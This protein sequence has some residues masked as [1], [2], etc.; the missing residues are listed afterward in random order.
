[1]KDC[2]VQ[3]DYCIPP[4]DSEVKTSL[5]WYGKCVSSG[6]WIFTGISLR[7]NN[8]PKLIPGFEM[9]YNR[10]DPRVVAKEYNWSSSNIISKAVN[11]I[12]ISDLEFI[13][14]GMAFSEVLGPCNYEVTPLTINRIKHQ[15][16]FYHR[17]K[18]ALLCIKCSRPICKDGRHPSYR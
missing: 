12:K 16:N 6:S 10:R 4:H 9:D 14:Q 1:M 13:R 18:Q 3:G 2:R 5:Q 7:S 15:F 17:W 8:T 11:W